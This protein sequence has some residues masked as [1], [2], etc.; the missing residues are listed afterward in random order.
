MKR[1]RD[2]GNSGQQATRETDPAQASMPRFLSDL[3]EVYSHDHYED[4]VRNR[5][6]N[7]VQESTE[8]APDV[9]LGHQHAIQIVHN[10]V[11]DDQGKQV[12]QSMFRKDNADRKRANNRHN[13]C[14]VPENKVSW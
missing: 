1:L 9:Q 10:V 2:D 4:R 12:R 3:S 5:V 6:T 11:V 7:V 8:V 14:Q 13:V